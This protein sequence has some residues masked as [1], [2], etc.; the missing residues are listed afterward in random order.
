MTLTVELQQVSESAALLSE[1]QLQ[2]WLDTCFP[3]A[4]DF[5]LVVRVVDEEESQSLNSQYRGKD[6]PTNVLSFPFD[7]PE[8]VPLEHLG[9]LVMCAPVVAREALEQNKI[10]WQHWAHLLIHG[11]LHLQGYDHINDTEAEEMEALEVKKLAGMGIS[12]PYLA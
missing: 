2:T 6:Y 9:D 10:E 11:V 12:D 5:S 7:V 1:A 4:S 8:G 3:E